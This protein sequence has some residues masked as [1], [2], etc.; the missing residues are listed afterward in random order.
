MRVRVL[1]LVLVLVV[2][3]GLGIDLG[4]GLGWAW[5]WAWVWAYSDAVARADGP[6]IVARWILPQQ[7]GIQTEYSIHRRCWAIKEI[8]YDSKGIGRSRDPAH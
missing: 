2:V 8:L 1:V 5:A 6:E 3:L 7:L 4:I